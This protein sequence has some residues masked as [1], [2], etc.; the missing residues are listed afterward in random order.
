VLPD[1][2]TRDNHCADFNPIGSA[3]KLLVSAERGQ[4]KENFMSLSIKT[5]MAVGLVL[6]ATN[7]RAPA[8]G[9]DDLLRRI[10][11]QAN[12]IVCI[13]VEA[14]HNSKLGSS[15]N[16]LERRQRM[17]GANLSSLPSSL[18]KLV[19]ASHF[20]PSTLGHGWQIAVGL[21]GKNVT[22]E[23]IA[24]MESGTLDSM[25]GKDVVLG[26]RNAYYAVFDPE[27]VGMRRPAN[28][29]ETARWLRSAR[30]R[31][32]PAV[33]R[34]LQVAAARVDDKTQ[35][36]LGIDL[37]DVFDMQ[38][39]KQKL[40]NSRTMS[41]SKADVPGM[42]KLI[43][44]MQGLM[45][46]INVQDS[47]TGELRL[48]FN[49]SVRLA[50]PYMKQLVIEVL[51]NMGAHLE[52]LAE[53]SSAQTANTVTLRGKV[54]EEMARLLLS[55]VIRPAAVIRSEPAGGGTIGSTTDDPKAAASLKYFQ[56]VKE[57]L[58]LLKN[59]KARSFKQ[60]GAWYYKGAEQIDDLPIL[61]VDPELLQYGLQISLTLKG[62]SNLA[63]Q[64]N[65]YN[66]IAEMNAVTQLTTVPTN[67]SYSR[68]GPWGGAGYSYTVPGVAVADNTGTISNLIARNSASEGAIR[69]DTWKNIDGATTVMRQK[70]TSKY[71]IEFR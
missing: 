1:I 65:S 40:A 21:L 62:L 60:L 63:Q 17:Y 34:Y 45:L 68:Y 47:M 9:F 36:V 42:A 46:T 30:T 12:M 19:V 43:S 16:W 2:D 25:D 20:D 59:C 33:S 71:G 7:Q 28:R 14:I 67:Y 32:Q 51:D 61:N 49:D 24:K 53:W 55:A 50:A 70:M 29:Q 22:A 56:H 44:G 57:Q 23:Q 31:E 64:T 66:N 48:D 10:P 8:D 69:T 4:A 18:K 35:F 11:D 6:L 15:A 26:P 58:D 3:P 39:V 37:T 52:D 27:V 13:D 5:A 38:G 54:T 41:A